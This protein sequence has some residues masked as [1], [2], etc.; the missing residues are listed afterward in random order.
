MFGG[1][2]VNFSN[3]PYIFRYIYYF[4]VTAVTQR[5]L[6]INDMKCCYLT[7]NCH[8]LPIDQFSLKYFPFYNFYNTTQ[9]Q[10]QQICQ[11]QEGNDESVNLGQ[12]SLEV[13]TFYSF[14]FFLFL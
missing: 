12:Y 4:S 11:Q 13:N 6:L 2:L 5:I 7:F 1:L 3:I 10:N 14:L 9:Y 8:S